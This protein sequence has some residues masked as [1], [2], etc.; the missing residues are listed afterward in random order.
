MLI[1]FLLTS[2]SNEPKEEVNYD[3]LEK[4]QSLPVERTSA[5]KDIMM[6]YQKG[7]L[8]VNVK[9]DA[10]LTTITVPD[11]E[12]CPFEPEFRENLNSVVYS[13]SSSL[14]NQY[15]LGSESF[16]GLCSRFQERFFPD[17][18]D[19]Y[20]SDY[21]SQ[22][23]EK[24]VRKSV[25]DARIKNYLAKMYAH[26][27]Y[28]KDEEEKTSYLLFSEYLAAGSVGTSYGVNPMNFYKDSYIEE[29]KEVIETN[30]YATYCALF[31]KYG[32]EYISK[33]YYAPKRMIFAGF[34]SKAGY[35][36]FSITGYDQEVITNAIKELQDV[37][38]SVTLND[39]WINESEYSAND[40]DGRGARIISYRTE[41][42]YNMLPEKYELYKYKDQIKA[43]YDKYVTE[44]VNALNEESDKLIKQ[45]VYICDSLEGLR[46]NS[47][48]LKKG[49]NLSYDFDF[50]NGEKL[51]DP[52]ELDKMGYTRVFFSPRVI[53]DKDSPLEI[54]LSIGGKRILADNNTWYELSTTDLYSKSS[55][56]HLKVKSLKSKMEIDTCVVDLIYI[57]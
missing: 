12:H 49:R 6:D 5:E 7:Y 55:E 41:H 35:T 22:K 9:I 15:M 10:G 17:E 40:A 29:L 19:D 53:S 39:Y 52:E 31:D 21:D 14:L 48:T 13:S 42:F 1:P 34:S 8:G 38:T 25:K 30:E 46:R 54:D 4:I 47:Y 2:C 11:D 44:K 18:L 32:T 26:T 28:Q 50:K 56:V 3:A 27:L 16:N 45:P 43:A 24:I 57:K 36:N 37:H 51:Y 33:V 20:I 23:Q